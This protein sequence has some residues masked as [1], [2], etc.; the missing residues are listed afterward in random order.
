MQTARIMRQSNVPVHESIFTV[1]SCHIP[2]GA[3]NATGTPTLS[4]IRVSRAWTVR[5]MD[6][7]A[8]YRFAA[9]RLS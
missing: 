9:R 7:H 1:G 2:N 5:I 4:T 8:S 3:A 6:I